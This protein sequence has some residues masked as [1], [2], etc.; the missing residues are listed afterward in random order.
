MPSSNQL[1]IQ[2]V[3]W[4][5]PGRCGISDHAIALAW[6]LHAAFGV[7]TKFVALRDCRPGNLAF[8][9]FES[10][11]AELMETCNALNGGRPGA[12]LVHLSGYGYSPDGVPARLA[13]SLTQVKASSRFGIAVYFH[14]LFANGPPWKSAFW[15]SRRQQKAI[16]AIAASCD[17]LVT[18]TRSHA[19]WL[20]RQAG[21]RPADLLKL[22]PVFSTI[23]EACEPVPLQGRK[24]AMAVFG[25]P[26]ARRKAYEQ[27]DM[28]NK[29]LES[30]GITHFLDIGPPFDAPTD[31]RGIAV[32]RMGELSAADL[33]IQLSSCMFGFVHHTP[34]C[35]AKSS[36]FAAYCAQGVIPVVA[37][38]FRGEV[39]GLTDGI[40]LVSPTTAA[41]ANVSGWEEHSRA[42]WNWYM[43]HCVRLH[44]EQYAKWMGV[45]RE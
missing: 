20:E 27:L 14:E 42:A 29:L 39:D 3:P 43:T 16:R 2:V 28:Q 30:I 11:P 23:G 31:L 40:H 7:N 24:P 22:L 19:D 5:K 1:L 32:R 10:T 44:A 21:Q 17:L 13:D 18:N 9:V 45:P 15:H 41:I 37:V 33:A 36:I 26:G 34:V 6:E 12:I 35:L 38:P 8:P 4:L 25:L